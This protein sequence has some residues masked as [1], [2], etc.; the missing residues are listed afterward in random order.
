MKRTNSMQS[1]KEPDQC[2]NI[3][4]LPYYF[5]NI[6]RDEAVEILVNIGRV[7]V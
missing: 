7:V 3:H 1:D 2:C 6:S 5:D 4:N